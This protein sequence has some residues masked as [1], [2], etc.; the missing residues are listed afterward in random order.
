MRSTFHGLET[1]RRS[2]FVHTTMMQTLGHNIANA[3]TDG[4]TRQRVNASA[5]RPLAMPGMFNSVAPGQLGTGVQYDSITRIRDSFLDV[6]FRRENQTLGSW[7]IVDNSIR[8]IEGF[9]N[10]PT[11]NGLRGVMDKFWN[12][13]EVLN[14]DPSL[15]SARVEVVGAAT[16]MTNMMKHIDESLTK[17]ENDIN[18]SMNIKV[19]EANDLINNIAKLTDTIKRVEGTGDNANDFR[20]QRDLLI[21]KLSTIVDVEVTEGE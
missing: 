17:L 20:D 15:L 18:S 2:L 6:Q 7:S 1:S 14:R 5:T 4:Y 19:N 8:S 13:W 11:E 16:N 3:S 9:F 21:D 12:S 10:E